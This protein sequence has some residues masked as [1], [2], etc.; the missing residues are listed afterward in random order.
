[1][2]PSSAD[3]A[4]RKKHP[5]A[6]APLQTFRPPAALFV[7]GALF[8]LLG[9]GVLYYNVLQHLGQT[10]TRGSS[11]GGSAGDILLVIAAFIVL[12]VGVVMILMPQGMRMVLCENGVIVAEKKKVQFIPWAEVAGVYYWMEGAVPGLGAFLGRRLSIET[13]EGRR[14]TI[15]GNPRHQDPAD[16][17]E[18][19]EGKRILVP[20]TFFPNYFRMANALIERI[21]PEALRAAREGLG[22]GRPVPFGKHILLKPDGFH[23]EGKH[24]PWEDITEVRWGRGTREGG[25][26]SGYDTSLSLIGPAKARDLSTSDVPNVPVLLE[27]LESDFGVK[28]TRATNG[29]F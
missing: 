27:L 18:T 2:K 19:T 16:V 23:W 9:G 17:I 14:V 1:M 25:G 26:R 21:R 15:R 3:A 4:L 6:G 7:V 22:R 12:I 11:G 10:P 29:F 20:P 13:T 24:V 5:E 28:V 8:I